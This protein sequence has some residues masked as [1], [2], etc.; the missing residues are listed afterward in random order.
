M[1]DKI[2][3]IAF[4]LILLIAN[5]SIL[6]IKTPFEREQF[7]KCEKQHYYSKIQY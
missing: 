4:E 1:T 2:F 3:R 7:S 6:F 5:L